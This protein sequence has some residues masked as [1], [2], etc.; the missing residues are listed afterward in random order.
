[1]VGELGDED[2]NAGV[3]QVNQ[4]GDED[5]V[6][7]HDE[8]GEELILLVDLPGGHRVAVVVV[9][10]HHLQR[11]PYHEELAREGSH[12]HKPEKIMCNFTMP[13]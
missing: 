2:N 13:P 8:E 6:D 9:G 1:M 12:Y 3:N 10:V 11:N 5:I 4:L 7:L